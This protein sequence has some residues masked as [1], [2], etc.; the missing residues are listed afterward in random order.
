[1]Q[2][3][4]NGRHRQNHL[5][6]G[7]RVDAKKFLRVG[8][9]RGLAVQTLVEVDKRQIARDRGMLATVTAEEIQ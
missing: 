2:K 9:G 8:F 6:N 4:A 3:C 5:V 7:R 1:M